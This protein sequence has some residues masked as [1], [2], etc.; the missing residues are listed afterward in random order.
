M[1]RPCIRRCQRCDYQAPPTV[2]TLFEITRLPLHKWF[3]AIYLMSADKGGISAERLRK[4]IGGPIEVRQVAAGDSQSGSSV[5]I[6]SD[7]DW[8]RGTR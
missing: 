4:I 7:D 2:G 5:C 8:L 6:G 1:T 3:T